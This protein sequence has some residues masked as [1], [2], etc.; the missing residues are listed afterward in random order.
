MFA[1]TQGD[2]VNFCARHDTRAPCNRLV[3]RAIADNR[4]QQLRTA[5]TFSASDMTIP[6]AILLLCGS[7]PSS[8]R[9]TV[10]PTQSHTASR[11]ESCR[12]YGP[13]LTV[14]R[15]ATNALETLPH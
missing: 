3:W 9:D 13:G 5:D 6:L 12:P 4:Y 7:A 2:D 1:I 8:T 15:R 10:Y 14:G 11:F